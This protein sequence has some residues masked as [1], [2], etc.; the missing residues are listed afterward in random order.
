LDKGRWETL[1]NGVSG[2]NWFVYSLLPQ[3]EGLF[4]GGQFR[5][6]GE[7]NC[8]HQWQSADRVARW[9]EVDEPMEL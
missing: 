6:L 5:F 3:P 1:G 2:A 9:V 8:G 7:P 4:V